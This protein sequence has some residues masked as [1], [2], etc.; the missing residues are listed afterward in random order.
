MG[1]GTTTK[2]CRLKPR[3]Q[4]FTYSDNGPQLLSEDA[5]LFT[6]NACGSNAKWR[7]GICQFCKIEERLHNSPWQ[8]SAENCRWCQACVE[9]AMKS[10]CKADIF[11]V[12]L[13]VHTSISLQKGVVW[14]RETHCLHHVPAH[15]K[16]DRNVVW[17]RRPA[18][19]WVRYW[20]HG[21][22]EFMYQIGTFWERV[23]R[24]AKPL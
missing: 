1:T 13:S 4:R 5:A 19:T 18:C 6:T 8:R 11:L 2:A 7:F 22:E 24:R 20:R 16:V 23:F 17:G 10:L 21:Y 15:L 14:E 3:Y 12:Y 9:I